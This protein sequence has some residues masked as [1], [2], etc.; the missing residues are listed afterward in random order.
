MSIDKIRHGSEITSEKLN[1]LISAVN[2][3][4]NDN[5]SVLSLK[6]ELYNKLESIYAQLDKCS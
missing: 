1:E 5:R 2:K 6:Q 4:D 3:M